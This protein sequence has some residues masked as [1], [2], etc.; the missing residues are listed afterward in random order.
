M[1]VSITTY[2]GHDDNNANRKMIIKPIKLNV[3]TGVRWESKW[4]FWFKEAANYSRLLVVVVHPFVN[5]HPCYIFIILIPVIVC[6][7]FILFSLYIIL[8]NLFV[9][10][11]FVSNIINNRAIFVWNIIK[12]HAIFFSNI[13]KNRAIFAKNPLAASGRWLGPAHPEYYHPSLSWIPF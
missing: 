1:Y 11:I 10:F 13:I 5:D 4:R 6:W 12:N 2:S 9:I 7:L 8:F 3:F